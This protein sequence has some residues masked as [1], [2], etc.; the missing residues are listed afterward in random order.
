[1]PI[2]SERTLEKY[3]AEMARTKNSGWVGKGDNSAAATSRNDML[4]G[5]CKP[6]ATSRNDMLTGVCKPG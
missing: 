5:V 3:L 6:A 2:F 4:T 1:M